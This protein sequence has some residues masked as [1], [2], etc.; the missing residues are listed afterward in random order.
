[1]LYYFF[2]YLDKALDVP[3]T[4]V[5]QYITFRSALAIIMSLLLSTI[6]GK[7]VIGFLRRQQIGETV[8]ELGLE[9]QT[10][11]AGTPT[12]GGI[13]IIFSTLIPVFLLAKLNNIYIILLIVSMLWMGLIG[14]LD[15]YIKVFKKDKEG[16]K[17]IFKV[18]GQVGLGVIVGVTLYFHPDVTVR[19][20]T[21]IPTKIEVGVTQNTI[22]PISLEEK[23]TATT[24]PFFKNNEFDY[25]ELLAWT[26][27]G[28]ENWAWLV[29]IPIVIFIITAVSNGANLTDGIDGL[30]A[31]TSAISVVALGVFTFVS[32]NII[33]SNYLNIMFI[34]NSG[35]M[36]VF[37]AAFVGALVG[38]L[39]YN[40]YPAAVFMGDT[41]SL[42]IG[43]VIA[44]LAIAVRKEMLIPVICG[45]FL[46]ENLSVVLQ[47]AYFK[48]T[49]KK[50]GEG[51][52]IFLM[53]PLHHHYQ[54][55][56]YHESKIVTRFWIVGILLAIVSIVTLKLR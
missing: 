10:Q 37:I 38:F 31:G 1:M 45:I 21:K 12:M 47:V 34:P 19:K 8:R 9:G 17:G 52:R 4:G 50:Y 40:S 42:T 15:D 25:A 44:V 29:F 11:K 2:E 27:Q 16:L 20:E 3:G 53:S 6:Y 14:F 32:G 13:I 54:K 35:E 43:G 41:G 46:A 22:N 5:F 51:R 7:R 28:Y 18:I 48:Y 30:A 36:T 33:F 49:K 55:K 24:I 56:G 23:S 39:W 26:G